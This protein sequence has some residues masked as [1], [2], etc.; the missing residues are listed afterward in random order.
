MLA[1]ASTTEGPPSPTKRRGRRGSV[2]T[3]LA[4]LQKQY[5]E[6]LDVSKAGL[7]HIAAAVIQK[8]FRYAMLR[9]GPGWKEMLEVKAQGLHR[10]PSRLKM[11]MKQVSDHGGEQLGSLFLV[12]LAELETSVSAT[13]D[14]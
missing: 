13:S 12:A 7:R 9:K 4:E 10:A 14:S 3:G 11:L 8:E 5:R 6:S 1:T 2:D